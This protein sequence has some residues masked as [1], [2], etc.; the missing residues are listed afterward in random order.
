MNREL[1]T[2][3]K[4]KKN[5]TVESSYSGQ[6]ELLSGRKDVLELGR[7]LVR[8]LGNSGEADTLSRWMSHHVAELITRAETSKTVTKRATAERQAIATILKIWEHRRNLPG[9]TDPLREY[10]TVLHF[11]QLIKPA[12]SPFG[13]F[14][15]RSDSRLAELSSEF[16][17]TFTR[18]LGTLL[19]VQLSRPRANPR[20]SAN[21]YLSRDEKQL[22]SAI[23]SW[24]RLADFDSAP[25]RQRSRKSEAEEETPL[26]F[27]ALGIQHLD[28]IESLIP[29]MRR[30]IQ[31]KAPDFRADSIDLQG[32]G[33]TDGE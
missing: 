9:H 1:T 16:F 18:L 10:E 15:G 28:H 4:R 3:K 22:L 5:D 29:A 24:M 14:R 7:Y 20:S 33:P 19:A 27:A 21:K 26:N 31:P 11:L 23:R 17:D 13:Y 30:E 25:T 2:K 6:T 32:A 12:S 8:E